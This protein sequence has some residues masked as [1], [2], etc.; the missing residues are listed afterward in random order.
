MIKLYKIDF[1]FYVT[2]ILIMNLYCLFFE[3]IIFYKMES[4]SQS[5][6]QEQFPVL[7]SAPP[8]SVVLRGYVHEELKN[9][10]KNLSQ[11]DLL[12]YIIAYYS[13]YGAT[14]EEITTAITESIL[15]LQRENL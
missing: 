7:P 1:Y 2:I 11:D 14:E 12:K 13:K 10:D 5:H 3:T 4:Q 8:L 9:N 15:E 6:S